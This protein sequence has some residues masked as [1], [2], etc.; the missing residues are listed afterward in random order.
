MTLRALEPTSDGVSRFLL[1]LKRTHENRQ[2]HT[3]P[4]ARRV[5]ALILDTSV[6]IGLL[7]LR[8]ATSSWP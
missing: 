1:G 8:T 5:A 6:L 2:T 7:D 3:F 4:A